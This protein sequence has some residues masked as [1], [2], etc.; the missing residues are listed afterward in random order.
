M[1]YNQFHQSPCY[2]FYRSASG[3]EL[4]NIKDLAIR[5]GWIVSKDGGWLFKNFLHSRDF[6][7]KGQYGHILK[8]AKDPAV[9]SSERFWKNT[10]SK[11]FALVNTFTGQVFI[12]K[13]TRFMSDSDPEFLL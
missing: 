13:N 7:V 4:D 3:V 9:I 10:N 1:N 11:R 2:Q 8:T 6:M 5:C 12:L